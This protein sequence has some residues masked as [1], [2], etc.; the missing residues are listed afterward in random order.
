MKLGDGELAG[1][2]AAGSL[3]YAAIDTGASSRPWQLVRSSG[4]GVNELGR[5]GPSKPEWLELAGSRAGRVAAAWATLGSDYLQ[6]GRS[7]P[8]ASG[9]SFGA[10]LQRGIASGPAQLAFA[11]ERQ[12]LAYPDRAGNTVLNIDGEIT[13]LTGD[14]PAVRHSA[15]DAAT[16][17]NGDDVLVLDRGQ[18]RT[19]TTLRVLGPGRAAR[20]RR[21]GRV[22]A[23]A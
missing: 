4:G 14:G 16:A 3:A 5:F 10:E 11:G 12:A 22:A 23:R 2:T 13:Q 17:R 1:L 15:R 6:A 21:R 9:G 8:T 7:L 20:E 19:R 18:T